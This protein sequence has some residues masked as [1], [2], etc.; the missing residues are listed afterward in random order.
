MKTKKLP[1]ESFSHERD[2][3]ENFLNSPDSVV[4]LE[5]S[6]NPFVS[7]SVRAGPTEA[8][9]TLPSNNNHKLTHAEKLKQCRADCLTLKKMQLRKKYPRE[10]TSHRNMLQRESH[11]SSALRDFKDFL[12]HVGPK[13]Y[14][15]ATLDRIDNSDPEYAPGKVRWADGHT[16][17]NN[18][19]TSRLFDDPDGNQYTVAELAKRQNLTPNAIHQ[20]L[21]RGWS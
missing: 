18:R 20:R 11:I 8:D 2:S 7:V 10:A 3:G 5:K 12:L 14:P 9:V 1:S 13:R 16:Q 19:S 17:S 15:G 6:Q 21:R 4:T